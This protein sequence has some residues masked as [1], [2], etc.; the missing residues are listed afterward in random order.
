MICKKIHFLAFISYLF[1][2]N[3]VRA[4]SDFPTLVSQLSF[5]DTRFMKRHAGD[6]LPAFTLISQLHGN[7]ALNLG[8]GDMPP[9]YSGGI[10]AF[11][12]AHPVAISMGYDGNGNVI[13]RTQT[14]HEQTG[15]LT[16][17]EGIR[18]DR[19]EHYKTGGG[20]QVNFAY[21]RIDAQV[22]AA[23]RFSPNAKWSIYGIRDGYNDVRMPATTLDTP[24]LIRGYG[25]TVLEL[26]NLDGPVSGIEASTSYQL[27]TA[28]SD[29][30]SLRTPASIGFDQLGRW[31]TLKSEVRGHIDGD[32]AQHE[33]ALDFTRITGKIT[34]DSSFAS[35]GLAA[36]RQP[37]TQIVTSG[38]AWRST[39]KPA[40][41]QVLIL[42]TRLDVVA[43]RADDADMPPHVVG[44]FAAGFN[45]TPRQLWKAYYGPGLNL[46]PTDVNVSARI[47][48]EWRYSPSAAVFINAQ[49]MVR[50]PDGGERY[51]ALGAPTGSVQVGNP[52]LAPEAH[53]RLDLGLTP[54]SQA[55]GF[56]TVAVWG[57][58]V[59]D[60][61]ALDRARGQT[62]IYAA[63]SAVISRNI[64]AYLT[65][66]DASG[67]AQF[68]DG[69]S[70][71][72]KATFTRG[73]NMT[74][75]IALYQVPPLMGEA[76]LTQ[77]ALTTDDLSW[78]I[79]A[80][81]RFSGTQ[82]FVDSSVQTG[83][84]L[85]NGGKTG[86]W[87]LY[88]LFNTIKLNDWIVI[89]AGVT[90]LLDKRY[91]NHL[92][93]LPQGATAF[94]MEGPGRSVFLTSTVGF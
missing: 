23:Y 58:R 89:N 6:D 9:E 16:L 84:G 75:A 54:Y 73:V 40:A 12:L 80:A 55:D 61:I 72:V 31:A 70:G 8:R 62:G 90:N 46:S 69:L 5:V 20:E 19:Q 71:R 26:T 51:Y 47:R 21:D 2:I 68:T 22:A 79:S 41:D 24:D 18:Y 56:F 38:M 65:G 94:P 14:A 3:N 93:P 30:F 11:A 43:S 36:Y 49:R 52:N 37:A 45:R 78:T 39:F 25:G 88:D 48:Y 91:R 87:I 59:H 74:D 13:S 60:F 50:S 44:A 63:D 57:D 15:P 29:N 92:N 64:E 81:S 17:W 42:G 33:L 1:S 10:D 66:I 7:W 67:R 86:A 34:I 28:T 53:H 82:S 83:S 77:R 4:E 32:Y 35:N 27:T 85:D 76:V